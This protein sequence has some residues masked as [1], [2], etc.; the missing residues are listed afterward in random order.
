MN[1]HSVAEAEEQLAR[2]TVDASEI[3]DEHFLPLG[4]G[5]SVFAV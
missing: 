5:P 4:V 2:T 3:E 1:L